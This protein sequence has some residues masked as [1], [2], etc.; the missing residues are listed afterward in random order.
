MNIFLSPMIKC[1]WLNITFDHFLY[2][3]QVPEI[4]ISWL[5]L[6]DRRSITEW[7]HFPKIKCHVFRKSRIFSHFYSQFALF[8]IFV[9]FIWKMVGLWL[10]TRHSATFCF[11]SNLMN[12]S[13]FCFNPIRQNDQWS[14]KRM[15]LLVICEQNEAFFCFWSCFFKPWHISMRHSCYRN[16]I[17]ALGRLRESFQL[18]NTIVIIID[19]KLWFISSPLAVTKGK[20]G[21]RSSNYRGTQF[22]CKF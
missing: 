22:E 11:V 1:A 4:H 19:F 13:L 2:H 9:Y 21:K 3:V 17:F 6:Y 15:C 14:K 20:N 16:E 10:T 12:N 18:N 5:K 7:N 8:F